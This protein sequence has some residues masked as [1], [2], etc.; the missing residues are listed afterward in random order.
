MNIKIARVLLKLL[1]T[2]GSQ[3]LRIKVAMRWIQADMRLEYDRMIRAQVL[4]GAA[5]VR[6]GSWWGERERGLKKAKA[7]YDDKG[8]PANPDWFNPQYSGLFGT[9]NTTLLKVIRKTGLTIEPFDVIQNA[10]AGM[11][12][13]GGFNLKRPPYEAGKT[14][15]EGIKNGKEHPRSVAAGKLGSY[16]NRKVLNEAK[17]LKYHEGIPIGV[18]D[19][20][21]EIADT[22]AEEQEAGDFL[23]SII[24]GQ[25]DDPLG[26][27]I[28]NF[29]RNT[30]AGTGRTEEV[31]NYWLDIVENEGRIPPKNEVSKAVGVL[32]QDFSQKYWPKGW[33]R[34]FDALWG[35]TSIRNQ[36]QTRYE[37]EGIPWFQ[38]KPNWS[39]VL[40]KQKR[41]RK[42]S[43]L[44]VER[45]VTRWFGRAGDYPEW[46]EE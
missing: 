26:K 23:F 38:E 32:P 9:L 35:T 39:A 6:E 30:W 14:L 1:K 28:R 13:T 17:T 45:V 19:A 8:Y 2:A 16:L 31:M 24:F 7:F 4:E 10:L 25:R 42:A 20:E 41:T 44:L 18:D 3:D 21:M 34:V 29:M 27:K 15:A 43:D 11:S 40:Q 33:K 37:A 12:L 5:G 36:L 46:S 22:P